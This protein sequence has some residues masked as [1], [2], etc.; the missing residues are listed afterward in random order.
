MKTPLDRKN[1]DLNLICGLL[2]WIAKL[3]TGV[4]ENIGWQV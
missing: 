1:R 4:L 2:N 3:K